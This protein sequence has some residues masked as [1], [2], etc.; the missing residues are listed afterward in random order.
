M[1][2]KG[3]ATIGPIVERT[4]QKAVARVVRRERAVHTLSVDSEVDP[5][6][7]VH[8]LR[9]AVRKLRA[10]LSAF[11]PYLDRGFSGP[12]RRRLSELSDVLAAVRDLDVQLAALDRETT[13]SAAFAMEV[14][15]FLDSLRHRRADAVRRLE[16]H[17]ATPEHAALIADLQVDRVPVRD[18]EVRARRALRR[19]LRKDWR[20]SR[21]RIAAAHTGSGSLHEVR[22]SVKRLR[23][24]AELATD[25]LGRPAKRLATQA[26][27]TQDLLG[28]HQDATVLDGL[29]RTYVAE[30]GGAP[31][32]TFAL[33]Q[34][35]GRAH[36]RRGRIEQDWP[37][38]RDRLRHRAEQLL[39]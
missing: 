8:R 30:T 4:I 34:L 16:E 22:K 32:T 12:L 36:E 25:P 33:G 10:M 35:V 6:R 17:V 3:S 23:Y 7:A 29:V 31:G 38:R 26:R 19:R 20:R 27:R 37:H 15:P 21:D 24:L 9:V 39:G 11:G 13:A 5:E 14:A 1:G 18:G 28:A 2:R